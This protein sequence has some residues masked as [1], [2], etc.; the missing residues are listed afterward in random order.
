MVKISLLFLLIVY[1]PFPVLKERGNSC[2][3][4]NVETALPNDMWELR[5][6]LLGDSPHLTKEVLTKAADK[7]DMPLKLGA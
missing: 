6:K 5:S 1:A 4:T 2:G 7:T 3:A